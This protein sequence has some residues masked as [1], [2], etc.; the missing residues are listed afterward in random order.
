MILHLTVSRKER[1]RLLFSWSKLIG[2]RLG[3]LYVWHLLH[4]HSALEVIF[5]NRS[6]LILLPDY[7]SFSIR[8]LIIIQLTE[9][10]Q[11]NLLLMIL[12][13]NYSIVRLIQRI[14]CRD[15]V[16]SLSWSDTLHLKLICIILVLLM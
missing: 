6:H 7:H 8:F 5:I 9:M 4:Y 13:T 3:W 14:D 11:V 12:L 16:L 15:A 2:L 1:T 10:G